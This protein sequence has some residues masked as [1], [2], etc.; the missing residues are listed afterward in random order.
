MSGFKSVREEMDYYL[1]TLGVDAL[2]RDNPD[3][4]PRRK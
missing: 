3:Q 4:F 1:S 2:L